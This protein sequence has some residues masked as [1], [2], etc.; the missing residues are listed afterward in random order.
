MARCTTLCSA[1]PSSWH[2]SWTYRDRRLAPRSNYRHT[3]NLPNYVAH[4]VLRGVTGDAAAGL[5]A[6]MIAACNLSA[7]W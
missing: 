4:C 3:Y 7:T 6:R 5:V 2:D 1:L